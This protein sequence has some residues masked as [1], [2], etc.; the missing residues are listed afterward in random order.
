MKVLIVD[1]EPLVR[2]SLRRALELSNHQVFEAGDGRE[3]LEAWRS[4]QPDIVFLD[5]LMPGLTG[6]LV[7]QEI[8][9]QRGSAKVLLISAYSGDYN[10][11]TAKKMGAD[12]FVAK[13]FEDVFALVRMAEGL[14]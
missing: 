2:R 3:G 12:L 10:L 5:V 14:K 6:P 13:P 11:E 9:N 4:H 8:G 1:D 7:L